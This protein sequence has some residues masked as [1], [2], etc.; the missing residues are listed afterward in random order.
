MCLQRSRQA[1]GGGL[2]FQVRS[3]MYETERWASPDR[4]RPRWR[5]MRDPKKGEY[6]AADGSVG[7]HVWE[8]T[9]NPAPA[10]DAAAKKISAS[11]RCKRARTVFLLIAFKLFVML[12]F[13]TVRSFSQH[14]H[15]FNNSNAVQVENFRACS[16]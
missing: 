2:T 4:L 3:S 11:R 12:S 14:N 6:W 8:T 9:P 5:F 13:F 16:M 7:L 1:P 10:E 15:N